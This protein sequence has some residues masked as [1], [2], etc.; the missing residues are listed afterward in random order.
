MKKSELISTY[1]NEL[2]T[3]M[4]EL[5]E[6]VI[7]AEGHVDIEVYI[8]DNGDIDTLTVAHG[9][10]DYLSKRTTD[11]GE[12]FYV[13]TIEGF[14]IWQEEP[15]PDDDD[16]AEQLLNDS[17]EYLVDGYRDIIP[18]IL[19]LAIRWAEYDERMEV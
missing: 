11:D 5:Y 15:R 3:R 4:A 19:D 18:D 10:N 7:R 1:Y 13:T 12:L 17:I 2:S 9:S 6:Q 14:N 16:E 8:W